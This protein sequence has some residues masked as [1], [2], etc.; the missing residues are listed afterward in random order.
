MF[1][2]L[3]VEI[4][5]NWMINYQLND[6]RYKVFSTFSVRHLFHGD[7]TANLT[8]LSREASEN[9]TPQPELPLLSRLSSR[10]CGQPSVSGADLRGPCPV[11]LSYLRDCVRSL[12]CRSRRTM[13]RATGF[14][15]CFYQ[16]VSCLPSRHNCLL[17]KTCEKSWTLAI[18]RLFS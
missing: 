9:N 11:F 8:F 10:E 6:K 14:L 2:S 7:S 13:P 18:W 16:A 3:K 5:G 1:K 12:W 17:P 15:C 4:Q